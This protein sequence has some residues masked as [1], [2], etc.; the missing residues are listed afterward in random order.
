MIKGL[1]NKVQSF[2]TTSSNS[3]R[4]DL[5]AGL[6]SVEKIEYLEW[7]KGILS[8]LEPDKAKRE[9]RKTKLAE[10]FQQVKQKDESGLARG[11]KNRL[12]RVESTEKYY[13][14]CKCTETR[15]YEIL[16]VIYEF[17]EEWP[18]SIYKKVKIDKNNPQIKE[19]L[20]FG[21]ELYYS[22]LGQYAIPA[23][24]QLFDNLEWRHSL[25]SLLLPHSTYGSKKYDRCLL[26]IFKMAKSVSIE[27]EKIWPFRHIITFVKLMEHYLNALKCSK[28]CESK[29]FTLLRSRRKKMERTLISKLYKK[30]LQKYRLT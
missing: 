20:D 10:I 23:S 30:Q 12:E 24:L 14:E 9:E 25:L 29:Y 15:P 5:E 8:S 18:A 22:L 28:K 4:Y 26:R 6:I 13:K 21:C 19:L 1:F 16:L 2:F 17:N 3:A 27:D 11:Y 7:E